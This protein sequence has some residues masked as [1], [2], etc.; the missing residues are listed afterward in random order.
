MKQLILMRHAKSDWSAGSG[1]DIARPLNARGRKSAAA[2]GAWLREGGFTPDAVL[3]SA[4]TRTQETLER[5]SLPGKP[6]ITVTRDLYL[7]EPMVMLAML[8]AA[9]GD[10]VL[11]LGHNPGSAAFAETLLETAPQHPDFHRFPT[12]ATL[13]ARFDITEWAVLTP[14]TGT[15]QQFIVPRELTD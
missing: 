11:M 4:A 15:P 1:S 10:S 14:G 6:Q 5:L 13:V 12:C 2:V 3:C 8:Q 7:A 9:E